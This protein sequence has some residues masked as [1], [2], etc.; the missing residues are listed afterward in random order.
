MAVGAVARAA[1]LIVTPVAPTTSGLRAATTHL[2]WAAPEASLLVAIDVGPRQDDDLATAVR[3]ANRQ[4]PPKER[5]EQEIGHVIWVSVWPG[6][7]D[8]ASLGDLETLLDQLGALRSSEEVTDRDATYLHASVNV[9][10][11]DANT[12]LAE[13]MAHLHEA[14][15]LKGAQ[16]RYDVEN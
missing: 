3:Q 8:A 15:A 7:A 1:D 16:I 13:V 6:D 2:A 9:R 10:S 12:A 4:P 11:A 14:D 5:H